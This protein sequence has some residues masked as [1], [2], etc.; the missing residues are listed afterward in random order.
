[1]KLLCITDQH[2]G[3]RND[4][5]IFIESFRKFYD[6]IVLPY[7]DEHN[8]TN[9]IDLGDTFDRR[10][11]INYYTKDCSSEIWFR[12][13]QERGVV[14]HS[15]VGNHTSYYRNT[16]KTN[17]IRALAEQFDNIIPIEAPEVFNFDGLEILMIPWICSGNYDETMEFIEGTSAEVCFAHLELSGFQMHRGQVMFDGMSSKIFQKFDI[18][19]SGHFHHRSTTGNISYLGAP[20]EM[21]WNDYDDPKGFHVFDTDTREFE[22]IENPYRMFY[23]I[24]YDDHDLEMSAYDDVDFSMYSGTYI[25]VVLTHK[26]NAFLFDKFMEKLELVN[27]AQVQVVEDHMNLDLADD[28]DIVNEAE[29]TLTIL[30]NYVDQFS[31]E[32]KAVDKEELNRVFYEIY[33]EA[34]NLDSS[35]N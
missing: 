30:R 6:N 8:I 16:L 22:F 2:W 35:T 20:Y 3:V 11:Y 10:K 5:Q 17:S 19:A 18:V 1:M 32:N 14:L 21:T 13:L 28:D 25:K 15:I 24:I 9:V 12:P 7:I 29:D 27:P 33:T 26:G 23:K 34:V 31:A 4:S